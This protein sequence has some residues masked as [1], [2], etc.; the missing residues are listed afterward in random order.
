[1]DVPPLPKVQVLHFT[2]PNLECC[3]VVFGGHKLGQFIHRRKVQEVPSIYR[4]ICAELLVSAK[5][6]FPHM[7]LVF[8]IVND[9]ASIEN[10]L[11]ETTGKI[12]VI[13]SSQI[14]QI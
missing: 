6:A 7:T 2:G 13:F 3:F 11:C 4:N 9:Q 5:I 14:F 10:N 1:M 8:N 12:N